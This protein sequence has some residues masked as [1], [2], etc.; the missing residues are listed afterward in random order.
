MEIADQTGRF[1]RLPARPHG[2]WRLSEVVPLVLDK[3]G[4]DLGAACP[5]DEDSPGWAEPLDC[6][7]PQFAGA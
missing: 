3:Y 6:R 4:V 5:A 2:L 1:E 7:E